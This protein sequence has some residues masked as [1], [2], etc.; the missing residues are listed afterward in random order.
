MWRDRDAVVVG[1]TRIAG[2]TAHATHTPTWVIV[3]GIGLGVLLMVW[4]G[5]ALA[6]AW[7]PPGRGGDDDHG[8]GPGGGGL[9]RPGPHGGDPP[10]GTEIWWPD[11]ER[12]FA[13]YGSERHASALNSRGV[14]DQ[15][16]R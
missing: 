15:P 4:L 12:E 16:A 7:R 8:S 11:F 1:L 3:L 13:A 6:R 5:L 14:A 2:R 10:G 9:W